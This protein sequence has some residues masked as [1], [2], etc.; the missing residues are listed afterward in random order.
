MKSYSHD[1][2]DDLR[3]FV[4]HVESLA[5]CRFSRTIL[6]N[7]AL[8]LQGTD[9]GPMDFVD[10]DEDDCR[11]FLLGLRILV[12][13]RDGLSLRKIWKILATADDLELLGSINRARSPV[14]L[15]LDCPAMFGDPDGNTVSNQ[16][17]FDTFLYG[18]YAHL[19]KL[20][21]KR[22]KEW[23]ASS[24]FPFLKL[25]FLMMVQIVYSQSIEMASIVRKVLLKNPE[26]QPNKTVHPTTPRQVVDE[27][28]P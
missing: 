17:V 28:S 12:Q 19:D 10:L 3:E 4:S 23:N 5:S 7:E 22:F 27:S 15:A 18:C 13:N 24:S 25:I 9:S 1:E 20:H 2:L 6:S 8:R 11:S 21:R 14:F 26:K 16:L